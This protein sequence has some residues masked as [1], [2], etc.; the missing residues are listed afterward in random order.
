MLGI[1]EEALRWT[2]VVFE[3]LDQRR[4]DRLYI[5]CVL[6]PFSEYVVVDEEGVD[7]VSLDH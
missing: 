4:H 6:F 5:T 1:L 3:K 7:R 2:N